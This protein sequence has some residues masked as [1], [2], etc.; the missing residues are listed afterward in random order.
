LRS[1]PLNTTFAPGKKIHA[2]ITFPAKSAAKIVR[3]TTTRFLEGMSFR[4][5]PL[6]VK[7]FGVEG[8]QLSHE[9]ASQI[10]D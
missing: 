7:L 6:T 1:P 8:K 2:Q 9:E 3:Y 5:I 4:N 10:C